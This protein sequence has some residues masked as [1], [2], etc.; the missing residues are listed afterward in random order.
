MANLSSNTV[1]EYAIV[2]VAV[3]DKILEEA[4]MQPWARQCIIGG[5]PLHVAVYSNSMVNVLVT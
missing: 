4:C 1:L 3:H 2:A 5:S